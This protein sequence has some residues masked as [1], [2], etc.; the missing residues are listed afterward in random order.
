MTPIPEPATEQPKQETRRERPVIV[1]Q[2]DD[3]L[4]LF[5]PNLDDFNLCDDPC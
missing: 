1:V 3:S 4:I 2:P 5:G